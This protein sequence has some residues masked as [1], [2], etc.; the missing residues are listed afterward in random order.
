[1]LQVKRV[2]SYC[3]GNLRS[4]NNVEFLYPFLYFPFCFVDVCNEILRY[5]HNRNYH[6]PITYGYSFVSNL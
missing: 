5:L 1:M 2:P 4:A 3:C 6:D